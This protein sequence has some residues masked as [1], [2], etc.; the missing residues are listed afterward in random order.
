[1]VLRLEDWKKYPNAI[2]DITTTNK[3]FLHISLLYKKMGIKNHAFPLILLDPTLQGVNPRSP[4]LT[5]EQKIAIAIECSKNIWYFLREILKLPGANSSDGIPF[6]ANRA[7]IAYMWCYFNHITSLTIQPRQ[8]GKS[9]NNDAIVV[10]LLSFTF[11]TT[12]TLFT[13]SHQL[14]TINIDR[15]K[16]IINLL[17]WYLNPV[18]K[19]DPNN[20]IEISISKYNNRLITLV[21]QQQTAQANNVGRGNTSENI[22]I[23]E[24][25]Y[26]P[27]VDISAPVLLATGAAARENAQINGGN[28]CNMF[29]TTPG[30]LSSTSG[31]YAR[32]IYE[33]SSKWSE[34]YF[35]IPNIEEL[36]STIR[37]NSKE[38][39]V[40][41]LLEFNHRQLGKDDEWLRQRIKESQ[42]NS[43][44]VIEA[45]YL[46]IWPAGSSSSP[47][48]KETIEKF[49]KSER[50]IS[51]AQICEN[52]Y[53]LN[54]YVTEDV[55]NNKFYNRAIVAGMDCSEMIGRDATTLIFVDVLTGEVIGSGLFNKQNL[56]EFS[57]FLAS[58]LIKYPNIT[59]VPE[60]KSSFVGILDLLFLILPTKNV[61][62]FRRIFNRVIQEININEE[63]TEVI[64]LGP[65]RNLS[66]YNKYKDKFGFKTAGAGEYS[67]NILYGQ[68][69]SQSAKNL[70]H[71]V[72]DKNLI[73]E[74][75]SI[76]IKN[77]RIDHTEG[78]HDDSVIAWCLATW[79]LYNAKNK[80][81]Y[82]ID[83]NKVLTNLTQE[84]NI[85]DDDKVKTIMQNNIKFEINNITKFLLKC[86][87]DIDR[88]RALNRLKILYKDIDTSFSNILSYDELVKRI[89]IERK[90]NTFQ[91]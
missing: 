15:L 71:L 79:F 44:D 77:G 47:F 90:I 57:N 64:K 72:H 26:I 89:D 33:E 41:I 67:R 17:P 18:S 81:F 51:Y 53:I 31:K 74:L 80:R 25:G 69:L 10:W 5:D 84:H 22:I 42:A 4:N 23:D 62:P 55:V 2:A 38:D 56:A 59:L 78:N 32:K 27:N 21:G 24:I 68:T 86:D 28:Y 9:I 29:T 36:H 65:K 35:D 11:N 37:K 61:D 14:R 52:S 1:M 39:K 75:L 46:N 82:G 12:I 76:V 7:N 49:N 54:W 48:S 83:E 13:K 70:A 19:K 50:S 43:K 16:E 30:Y 45:D 73:V 85:S 88:E 6:N 34:K 3:S 91:D 63:Y 40:Q 87:S 60:N 20:Q 8:T 58:I 66:I